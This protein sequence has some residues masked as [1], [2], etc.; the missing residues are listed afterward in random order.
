MSVSAIFFD[1]RSAASHHGSLIFD[2]KN[3]HFTS[4]ESNRIFDIDTSKLVA[5]VGSGSWVM[6][7]ADGGRLQWD[8]QEF[9]LQLA[10]ISAQG[11]WIQHL[12]ASWR[13]AFLALFVSI[14]GAWS[15]LTFGVPAGARYIAFSLP[16]ETD[17]LISEESIELL[18][19]VMFQPSELP[20]P[21]MGEIRTLFDTILAED[22]AYASFRL[23]FRKS[24][25][26][27]ANAFAV[28]GGLVIITDEMVGLVQNE[29]EVISVLAHEVGHLA[30]RH[31]LRILL[32]DSASAIIVAGLTGDLSNVTA[33]SATV[34]TMLMQAKYSRDFEREADNFAFEYL[35]NNG[36]DTQALS[37]LLKRIDHDNDESIDDRLSGWFSSHPS[38]VQRVPEDH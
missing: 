38:S 30:Q 20:K 25:K 33:L 21:K 31:G 2:G 36:L 22:H 15:I 3:L 12:E 27:G 24:E 32:Q 29:A 7:L 4:V 28:P 34:P 35:E 17:K 14:I 10:S 13:W 5:P 6:E 16:P 11:N 18:D 23:E 26:I 19:K 8:D 9:G 1:G 37:K